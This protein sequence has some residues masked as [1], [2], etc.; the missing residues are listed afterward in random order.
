VGGADV[1]KVCRRV[2]VMEIL[3]IH[4]C[5]WKNETCENYSMKGGWEIKENDG[6]DELNDDVFDIR[7]FVNATMYP[8]HNIKE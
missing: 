7:S 5:K 3:C 8:Q 6:G 1:G 4:A 2:N